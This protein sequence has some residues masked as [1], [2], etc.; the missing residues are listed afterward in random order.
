MPLSP[1]LK[2]KIRA[3]LHKLTIII[4]FN[5]NLQL[6]Y[7]DIQPVDFS[8]QTGDTRGLTKLLNETL[9]RT[10]NTKLYNKERRINP[11]EKQRSRIPWYIVQEETPGKL[12]WD[13]YILLLLLYLAWT[14]PSSIVF[15][16]ANTVTTMILEFW[17][18]T[19]FLLDLALNFFVTFEVRGVL[20]NSLSVIAKHYIATGFWFD[21][22]CSFP[23]NWILIGV[24]LG[25]AMQIVTIK[26]LLRLVR[27]LKIGPKLIMVFNYLKL[28]PPSVRLLISLLS[29]LFLLHYVA[30]GYWW[31][32]V[33]EYGGLQVC[34]DGTSCWTN[35]CVCSLQASIPQDVLL[36]NTTDVSWY[37]ASNPDEWVPNAYLFQTTESYFV[38]FYWA[39]TAITSVGLNIVPRSTN[40]YIYTIVVILVGVL[41]YALLISNISN[42]INSR[43]VVEI[44]RVSFLDKIQTFMQKNKVPTYFYTTI[45]DYYRNMWKNE[46]PLQNEDLFNQLSMPLKRNLRKI[47]WKDLAN[48][49]PILQLLDIHSYYY[50]VSHLVKKTY[51]PG[52]VITRKNELADTMFFVSKGKV[53]AVSL[54]DITVYYTVYPGDFFGELCLLNQGIVKRECSFRAVEYVDVYML[55]RNV[56]NTVCLSAPEFVGAIQYIA[57]GRKLF[58][59]RESILVNTNLTNTTVAVK[60]NANSNIKIYELY[61]SKIKVT[62]VAPLTT[63]PEKT[64]VTHSSTESTIPEILENGTENQLIETDAPQQQNVQQMMQRLNFGPA[65]LKP[66]SFF[67]G[68]VKN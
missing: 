49:Y 51:L 48:Q 39:I 12:I 55:S 33:Q 29:L 58:T 22:L 34:P 35:L 15:D 25:S 43:D 32:A 27:V 44:E 68:I 50:F 13:T 4:Q 10:V 60:M 66:L 63:V 31:L 20:Q 9:E 61:G 57:T 64:E 53:D 52:E 28:D 40:E 17:I 8:E 18:D 2:R 38:A 21:L 47:L 26:Q 3:A 56:F 11:A 36:F 59:R 1:S 42:V 24:N 37:S 16:T 65:E 46:D 23:L 14:V 19:F 45:R 30:C 62:Q 6:K 41:F 7:K 54:D 67:R 5:K